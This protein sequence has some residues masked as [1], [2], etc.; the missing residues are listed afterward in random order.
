MFGRGFMDDDDAQATLGLGF[1]PRFGGLS[2]YDLED[3]AVDANGEPME[4]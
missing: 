1:T 2:G 4:E 3:D